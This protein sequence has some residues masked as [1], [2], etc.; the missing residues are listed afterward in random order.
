MILDCVLTHYAENHFFRAI[1]LKLFGSLRNSQWI[2]CFDVCQFFCSLSERKVI[3]EKKIS[4]FCTTLIHLFRK[5][6]VSF[7]TK[8][9][10]YDQSMEI[11]V[12]SIEKVK[13][14]TY[15]KCFFDHKMSQK[16]K[17]KIYSIQNILENFC[18]YILIKRFLKKKFF[19]ESKLRYQFC[20]WK[21]LI[22]F[23]NNIL[24]FIWKNAEKKSFQKVK[25]FIPP[26]N[27]K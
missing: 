10:F 7:A 3:Q 22:I 13:S 16:S 5:K 4:L 8:N 26:K 20:Y 15:S 9:Q 19:K 1:N 2:K 11:K 24:C 17:Y 18:W 12:V 6:N 21:L 14:L 27:K 25:F 23:N